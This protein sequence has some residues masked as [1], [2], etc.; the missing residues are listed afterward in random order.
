MMNPALHP[1]AVLIGRWNTEGHHHLMPGVTLHGRTSFEWIEGGAFLMMRSEIDQPGV[2]TGVAI[3]GSDDA[4]GEQY[5]L[6][7]DERGV[8]RRC[9]VRMGDG[10][11]T[12]WRD[13]PGFSQRYTFTFAERNRVMIGRGELSRDG[14][15]W[16]PD[17]ALTYT[18]VAD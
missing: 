15:T 1:Y 18:R 14:S 16:E 6:Y 7:F 11:W 5:M 9:D 3:I 8:S 2:P 4:L 10:T 13:A 17:L 12:W